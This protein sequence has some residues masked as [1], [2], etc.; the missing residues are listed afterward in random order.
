MLKEDVEHVAG[1]VLEQF[2]LI[3][4]QKIFL[5]HNAERSCQARQGLRALRGTVPLA[6]ALSPV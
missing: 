3:V 5:C 6:M 1:Q 2:F 4:F